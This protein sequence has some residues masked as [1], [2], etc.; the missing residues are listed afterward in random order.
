MV[1]ALVIDQRRGRHVPSETERAPQGATPAAAGR[2]GNELLISCARDGGRRGGTLDSEKL[3]YK[4][5]DLAKLHPRESRLDG[6]QRAR[7][8]NAKG[9]LT[10]ISAVRLEIPLGLNANRSNFRVTSF[11]AGSS[12]S[13]VVCS[14]D[15]RKRLI[16]MSRTFVR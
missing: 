7:K 13:C 1:S 2:P 6:Q 11:L 4:L 12:L 9:E 15:Y 14:R 10:Q 3:R 8:I 5:R 16:N